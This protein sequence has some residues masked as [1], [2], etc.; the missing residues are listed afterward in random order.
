MRAQIHSYYQQSPPPRGVS[1]LWHERYRQTPSIRGERGSN[2]YMKSD[3]CYSGTMDPRNKLGTPK[4]TWV[5]QNA[6]SVSYGYWVHPDRQAL[7]SSTKTE[8]Q[9]KLDMPFNTDLTPVKPLAIIVTHESYA[10]TVSMV[11][12]PPSCTQSTSAASFSPVKP[13]AT[14]HPASSSS[15]PLASGWI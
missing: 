3:P 15:C 12:L 9:P 8:N 14:T 2:T 10:G 6:L 4:R 13:R 7:G 11:L 1:G 5:D